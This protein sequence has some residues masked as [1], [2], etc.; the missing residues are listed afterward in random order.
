M[1]EIE[2]LSESF[3]LQCSVF[4]HA[5]YQRH[6]DSML[7]T[8]TLAGVGKLQLVAWILFWHLVSLSNGP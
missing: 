1:G 2:R 8:E 5:E 3:I 4:K 6:S 7:R